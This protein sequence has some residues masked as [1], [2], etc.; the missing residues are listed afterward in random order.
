MVITWYGQ[1][2]FRVQSGSTTVVFD[3]FKKTIGLNPPKGEANMV[4]ITHEHDDHNNPNTIKGEP[5]IVDTPGEYE[6][7]GV[8]IL[9]VSSFHD[10]KEG[11]ENGLNTMYSMSIED[12]TVGHL[13]DLGQKHLT[14]EQLET[15]NGIDILM[16]PVGG[17]TTLDAERA[18]EVVNQIEPKISIPMHYKV[19]G[20]KQKLDSVETFLKEVGQTDVKPQEKLTI[21]KKDLP[22][23]DDKMEV[24]VL[25]L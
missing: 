24:V 19:K 13:G 23:E 16:V 8:R 5:F 15:L 17:G 2:C 1:S 7:Q 3:P 11:E 25:K 6:K 21:K 18:L 14:D 12:I 22:G 20:L 9:G 10:D 4:L